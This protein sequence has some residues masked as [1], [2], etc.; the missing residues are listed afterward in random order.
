MVF[1]AIASESTYGANLFKIFPKA[2]PAEGEDALETYRRELDWDDLPAGEGRTFKR[3][4]IVQ[5]M[6]V[7]V[8]LIIAIVTGIVTG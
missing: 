2:A 5:L 7:F 1:C 4:A 8:T 6:A 3:Q